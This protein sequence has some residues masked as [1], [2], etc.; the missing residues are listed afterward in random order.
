MSIITPTLHGCDPLIPSCVTDNILVYRV[1]A[2]IIGLFLVLEKYPSNGETKKKKAELKTC[3][4]CI[5][6]R[7][8]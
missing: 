4:L 6:S 5:R 3:R 8:L 1:C 7:G 2:L